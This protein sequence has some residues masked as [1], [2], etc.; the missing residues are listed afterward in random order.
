MSD[1]ARFLDA[2]TA[3]VS[4]IPAEA[5]AKILVAE[6]ETEDEQREYFL[7]DERVGLRHF[8]PTGDLEWEWAFR[9]GARHGWMYRWHAPDCLYSAESYENGLAHGTAYQW[10]EDGRR[11]GTCTLMHGTGLDLWREALPDGRI[12]LAEAHYMKNGLP[13][14]WE[15]WFHAETGVIWRETHWF[16]GE[17]HGIEREWN[18][19]KLTRDSPRYWLHSERVPK[20]KY[21]RACLKDATLLPFRLEDNAPQRNFP[22]EVAL[23]LV[24]ERKA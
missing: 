16:E 22:P 14:G 15:W 12:G 13:H 4:S 1:E 23:N 18:G 6:T 3:Y 7:K 17:R 20:P 11:I 8:S 2:K 21:V 24:H 9:S 5:T 19:E 10:A